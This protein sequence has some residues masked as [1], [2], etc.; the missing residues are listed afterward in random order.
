M[1]SLEELRARVENSFQEKVSPQ[2]QS[3]VE[4]Y[5]GQIQDWVKAGV[6]LQPSS[7]G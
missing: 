7:S 2:N 3:S 5:R 4:E 6:E 1:L